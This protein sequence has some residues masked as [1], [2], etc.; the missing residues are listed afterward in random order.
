MEENMRALMAHTMSRSVAAAIIGA[1]V[2]VGASAPACANV[3]NDWDEKAAA[4][5]TPMPP[6]HGQR[7]LAMVHVAMFDAVNSIERRYRPYLVQ[8]PADPT[9]SKE[10]AAA[11]AAAAV[12]ATI[13]SKT[14][15]EMK[16]TIATYLASIPDGG[17]K[18]DGVKL[19]EAVAARVLEARVNDG[20]DAPDAYRPR[21]TPGVYVPTP[22]TWASM[23]P[24][25]K[26]FA[27]ANPS[28]FRPNPPIS[29]ESKEWATDFN[30]VKDYG[31]KISAK[32]T[33]QQTETARFWLIGTEAYYPFVRQL[34][35]AKQMSVVDS[36]RFMALV[37]V[38]LNDALIAV[39]DAKYHYNFWRPITSIRN[40]DTDGNPATDREATWQPIDD[41]PMFPEYPCGHCLLSGA[42]AAVVEAVLGT[43]DIPEV[44]M[45]SAT[46]PGVT[47][48]WTNMTTFTEEVANARIWA[49]FHYRFSNR[50]GTDMGHK[51]GEYVVKSVMQPAV[52]D[53]R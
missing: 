2:A 21:T 30:E 1:W 29:L 43:K 6:Y 28:Q 51:I 14:A 37:T 4:V 48:R 9:T 12:L 20:A 3:I 42:F 13:D 16:V 36:A 40:G 10:A 50:V 31:G 25:M 19:G 17:A 5:V 35:T 34:V 18:S 22:I 23:W 8:L 44:A 11:A 39:L 26:P 47:H 53:S 24:N 33:V 49:G 7:V 27:I 15:G 41:T 45:T 46:A 38:G 32:R 52:T